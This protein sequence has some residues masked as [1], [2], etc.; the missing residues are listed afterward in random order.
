M[1]VGR[2]AGGAALAIVLA[3]LPGIVRLVPPSGAPVERAVLTPDWSQVAERVDS[4]MV[5]E[6]V[7]ITPPPAVLD[8]AVAAPRAPV[9]TFAPAPAPARA[10][11]EVFAL[12]IGI[13]DYPG[14]RFDLDSAV[15]DVDTIDAA[16]GGFGVPAGNRVV[17]RDGQAT[18]ATVRAAISSLVT[19]GGAGATYVLAYA[20]HARWLDDDTQEIV[21]ADGSSLLDR[22]LATLLAPATTQ[23][24]WLLFATCFAGGFTELLSPGRIL[25]GA[26]P[27]DRQAWEDPDLNGSYLVHYLVREGWLHGRAGDSVQEAFAYADRTLAREHPDRRPVQ[28]DEVGR[29]LVLGAGDPREGAAGGP[30]QTDGSPDQ[31]RPP[32]GSEP[33][34][35]PTTRPERENP[36]V[37]GVLYC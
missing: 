22:E 21:L 1:R 17:L 16:L 19:Q 14:R 20:G 29:P 7:A 4:S 36:C 31:G 12:L 24:M 18:R 27:A 28:V 26:A 2:W 35:P 34:S 13:D 8:G 6:E 25:T 30:S 32:S 11:G 5:A 10:D 33:S 9:S 15:A 37:L 23:R 3:A